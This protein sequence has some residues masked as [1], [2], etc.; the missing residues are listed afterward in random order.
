MN[1]IIYILV[2]LVPALL[3]GCNADTPEEPGVS[4]KGEWKTCPLRLN[5]SLGETLTRAGW[6]LRDGDMIAVQFDQPNGVVEGYA[7][8]S[9]TTGA[10]T[11]HY[12]GQMEDCV[13]RQ[14]NVAY[15]SGSPSWEEEFSLFSLT[16]FSALFVSEEFGSFSYG[17]GSVDLSASIVPMFARFKFKGVGYDSFQII[18]IE[19]PKSVTFDPWSYQVRWYYEKINLALESTSDGWESPYVYADFA[20][21]WSEHMRLKNTYGVFLL[22]KAFSGNLKIGGSYILDYPSSSSSYNSSQWIRDSYKTKKLPDS[23]SGFSSGSFSS[24]VGCMF[25]FDYEI[26]SVAA[27][28]EPLLKLEVEAS[29]ASSWTRTITYTSLNAGDKDHDDQFIYFEG[30]NT[31]NVKVTVENVE[32]KMT[33]IELSNF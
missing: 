21:D 23:S 31:Y 25:S 26:I 10:W 14:C 12:R 4:S 11:F 5:V 19:T 27:G 17:N 2:L 15:M 9:E 22:K 29:G 24:N 18:G 30:C 7:L 32:L 8:Y 6:E 13:D 28:R 3:A 1:K 20:E 16:P 33:N